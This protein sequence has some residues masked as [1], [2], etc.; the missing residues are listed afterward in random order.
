MRAPL[1]RQSMLQS[2]LLQLQSWS[3]RKTSLVREKF[4]NQRNNIEVQEKQYI[5]DFARFILASRTVYLVLVNPS[6]KAVFQSCS[7]SPIFCKIL[8]VVLFNF[9]ASDGKCLEVL[10]WIT[11]DRPFHIGSYFS[12]LF[13]CSQKFC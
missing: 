12:G 2:C 9:D 8:E 5:L 10:G 11:S 1:W 7:V 3:S 13:F 4:F 6:F